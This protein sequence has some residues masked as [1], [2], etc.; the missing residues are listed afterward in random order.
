[1]RHDPNDAP[2]LKVDETPPPLPR[3]RPPFSLLRAA[4]PGVLSV[5]VLP[6]LAI[7]IWFFCRIEPGSGQIAILIHKTGKDLPPGQLIAESADQK[8]IQLDVLAEGR[9]FRNP[10]SWDWE[11]GRITDVPAGK[12]AVLTRLHG[13]ELPPNQI[14]AGK[15]QKG[16]QADILAPGKYRINPYAYRVD[17]YDAISIRP[18]C[19]GVVTSL[20]GDDVLAGGTTNPPNGFLV[21][22]NMKGVLPAVLDPGTYYL[23][24]YVVSVVEVNL[25]SQRFEMSGPDAINFLTMDGFT[26]I[27]EGTLEFAIQS[28]SAALLTHRVGDMNDIIKKVILPRAR[29]FSRIEGS[30]HP[31]TTFI[32]GETRQQFQR[33]LEAHLRS[34]CEAWG[35]SVRSVLIRNINP[36]EEV[37]SIIRDREIAVQEAL[38]YENEIEQAVSKAELVK[39]EMLAQQ[40]KEKVEADTAA[41]R[42]VIAAEQEQAVQIVQANKNL[43]VAKIENQAAEA[44]AQAVLFKAGADAAVVKMQN[45]AEASVFE[46]QVQAF[47]NGLNFARYTFYKK[48]GPRIDSIL[49]T[50]QPG[51]LGSL[52]LPYLPAAKEV[53]P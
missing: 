7:F 20:V 15:G 10:Y 48:V 22:A 50:D 27:V 17:L 51:G 25:Q 26:V 23:N 49:T 28:E 35:V 45:E 13:A 30:K 43:E 34:T 44:Q 5:V 21:G 39:Q 6:A 16:I 53:N 38:R 9:Y 11:I 31:A 52:F 1:M 46:S 24:P 42:A 40:N 36:P 3:R 29:G 47:S 37:A 19:V 18:G 33:D 14:I 41:I 4:L 12:L 8:G 32:K 2:Y